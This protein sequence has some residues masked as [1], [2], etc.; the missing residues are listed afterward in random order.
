MDLTVFLEPKVDLPHVA[1]ILD[2]LG[3]MGRVET[4]RG[5]NAATMRALWAAAKG[6]RDVAL[7]DFVP[8]SVGPMTEVVMTEVV[9]EGMNS[10][11]AFNHFQ[12][13]FAR[14][15]SGTVFG[16]NHQDMSGWTG[17]GYF[18]VHPWEEGEK[19]EKSEK[20][21]KSEVAIDYRELPRETLEGWPPVVPNTDR[22]GRFVYEGMVD[23]MRGISKHVTIGR[24][25]KNDAWMNAWFVLCRV[26]PG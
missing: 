4:I 5:W 14:T 12:K 7:T 19:S 10:L 6:Y 3:P 13:R 24:A 25:R 20:S 8:S 23:V 16:Y 11:A 17:P 18:V 1:H 26:D 9:H 21:S 15:A 22:L 2:G